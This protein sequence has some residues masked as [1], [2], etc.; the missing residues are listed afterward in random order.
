[1]MVGPGYLGA[2]QD[3]E[4]EGSDS[5]TGLAAQFNFALG[6]MITEQLALNMDLV[7]SRAG[8]ADRELVESTVLTAVHM[9]AGVT[10]WIMPINIFIG[11]SV[12]LANSSIEGSQRRLADLELPEINSSDVGLGLHAAIGKQWWLGPRWGI[13]GALSVLTSLAGN[14]DSGHDTSRHVVGV[15]ALLNVTFH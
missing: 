1:L 15:G 6:H 11:A 9:G 10:Y 8:D 2:F 12:G 7:L 4:S 13:G 5:T 3:L 14:P